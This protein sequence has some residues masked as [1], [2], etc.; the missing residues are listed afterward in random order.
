MTEMARTKSK[1]T[2]HIEAALGLKAKV[3]G[4]FV[5]MGLLKKLDG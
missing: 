5:V 2:I 3:G 4:A 1:S